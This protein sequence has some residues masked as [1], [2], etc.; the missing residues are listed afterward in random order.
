MVYS[1][2]HSITAQ[3]SGIGHS[4][5]HWCAAKGYLECLQWL[6]KQGAD[7]NSLNAE[8]STPLHAAAANGQESIVQYLLAQ[9]GMTRESSSILTADASIHA[10]CLSV[11]VTKQLY[12]LHDS[13]VLQAAC[14]HERPILLEGVCLTYQII[15]CNRAPVHAVT[16]AD[17]SGETA[18]QAAESKKW[19]A[20]AA[21]IP[22]QPQPQE[23]P[24]ALPHQGHHSHPPLPTGSPLTAPVSVKQLDAPQLTPASD[25]PPN[26]SIPTSMAAA[27]PSGLT[28]TRASAY[29]RTASLPASKDAAHNSTAS[30]SGTPSSKDMPPEQPPNCSRES[31]SINEGPTSSTATEDATPSCRT[32]MSQGPAVPSPTTKPDWGPEQ[33]QPPPVQGRAGGQDE[34]SDQQS[35]SCGRLTP[36]DVGAC[37]PIVEGPARAEGKAYD[38]RS[39]LHVLVAHDLFLSHSC[40]G[41]LVGTLV[42]G[43]VDVSMLLQVTMHRNG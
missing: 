2:S 33:A 30:P 27:S 16:A 31:S 29:S 35:S 8:D 39:N 12:R 11:L 25:S 10:R 21:L 24:A 36:S 40:S 4:A 23:P 14:A 13:H 34:V 20:I 7:I 28:C 38:C 5:M 6:L 41:A 17:S 37:S 19:L 18:K 9:P 15:S 22:D 1:S 43:P 26:P 3:G 42:R 32:D